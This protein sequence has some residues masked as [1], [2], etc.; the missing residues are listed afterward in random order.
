MVVIDASGPK[1]NPE[2]SEVPTTS[3]TVFSP[4]KVICHSPSPDRANSPLNSSVRGTIQ[5]VKVESP[6]KVVFG[7]PNPSKTG[8]CFIC[9]L[10]VLIRSS[11]DNRQPQNSR[12]RADA[13]WFPS[14]EV[15]PPLESAHQ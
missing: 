4:A 14:R 1:L 8:I 13:D 2:L 12:L 10:P 11:Y 6:K 3:H 5:G 15:A 9:F 7:S